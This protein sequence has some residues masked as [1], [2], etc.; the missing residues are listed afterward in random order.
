MEER[1]K[2]TGWRSYLPH[3][4]Y[5]AE[6]KRAGY[7]AKF[8]SLAE[9]PHF[10]A[11]ICG[12]RN[13]PTPA[14]MRAIFDSHQIVVAKDVAQEPEVA[15]VEWNAV[16][17]TT[18]LA[19]LLLTFRRSYPWTPPSLASLTKAQYRDLIFEKQVRLVVWPK[20]VV[21]VITKS[22]SKLASLEQQLHSSGIEIVRGHLTTSS[23]FFLSPPMKGVCVALP[24][25]WRRI[26]GGL[27][28]CE[29]TTEFG[30][31]HPNAMRNFSNFFL[32]FYSDL[33]EQEIRALHDHGSAVLDPLHFS[34]FEMSFDQGLWD[35]ASSIL[36]TYCR[37]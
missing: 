15:I 12:S 37:L 21:E 31:L 25:C 7:L 24:I 27:I 18:A 9:I 5:L 22:N 34:R 6:K 20:S 3:V 16:A 28:D 2:S 17:A 30:G 26:I 8:G 14:I 13:C 19:D 1:I 35:R 4:P 36:A 23:Y 32:R 11:P 10:S 33:S 29:I